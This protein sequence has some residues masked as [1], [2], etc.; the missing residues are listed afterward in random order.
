[1]TS[2]PSIIEVF[3]APGCSKCSKAKI[4]IEKMIKEMNAV[5]QFTVREVNIVEELDY[6]VSL[7]I[8][9]TPSIAINGELIYASLP[10]ERILREILERYLND[11]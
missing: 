4:R 3:A 1:V 5:E 7:S 8:L 11:E 9:T 6:A 2:K 10:T